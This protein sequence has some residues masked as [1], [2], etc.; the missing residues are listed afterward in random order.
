M[1]WDDLLKLSL[2]GTERIGL[3]P[4]LLHRMEQAGAD[5]DGDAASILAQAVSLLSLEYRA[6][7]PLAVVDIERLPAPPEAAQN[8]TV[9]CSALSVRHLQMILN[10]DFGA[11]LREFVE[12]AQQYQRTLPPI[13]LPD[14]LTKSVNNLEFWELVQPLT[15]ARTE[16]LIQLNPAWRSLRTVIDSK[17]W[18]TGNT[19]ERHL[20]LQ[21]LRQYDPQRAT[22]L[23][24][25][26]FSELDRTE[27]LAL[28][29]LLK[30][31]SGDY[32]EAFLETQ[33]KARRKEVRRQAAELLSRLPD[34]A[35]VQAIFDQ[36]IPLINYRKKNIQ[37]EL[38]DLPEANQNG[39]QLPINLKDYTGGARA[40]YLG[41]L[42]ERIPPDRWE[43][44]FDAEPSVALRTW[45][46]SNEPDLVRLAL[47]RATLRFEDVHWREALLRHW[48]ARPDQPT[49]KRKAATRLLRTTSAELFNSIALDYLQRNPGLINEDTAVGRWVKKGQHRWTEAVS[50]LIIKG[51]Q[52]YLRELQDDYWHS[53]KYQ[54][55]L[56]AAGYRA[57]PNALERL[58]GGW[59]F[60]APN[61]QHWEPEIERM[62]RTVI[63]RKNM[64]HALA[65]N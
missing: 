12:V 39:L 15:G 37:V 1:E 48:V 59:D 44:L 57:H 62:L 9:A 21:R 60:T 11:A 32:D 23:L 31:K 10:G 16:W 24:Q 55:L 65:T 19:D 34:S 61:W 49:W 4:E 20:Y 52:H 47:V 56:R 63:F 40:N 28:L 54:T 8:A 46:E 25:E 30:R 7:L 45:L 29:K 36:V 22:E 33:L 43:S 64:R 51:L 41:Q 35:Y 2:L 17:W 38:P 58:K 3:P 27:Q 50:I 6:G 18:E 53:R 26:R 14:L 5:V 13:A 42:L